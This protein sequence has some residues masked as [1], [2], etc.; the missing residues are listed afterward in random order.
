MVP[1]QKGR[2]TEISLHPGA[3]AVSLLDLLDAQG[4]AIG[5]DTRAADWRMHVPPPPE[6]PLSTRAEYLWILHTTVGDLRIRLMPQH[7]PH[8]VLNVAWLTRIGFY[9]GL[10]FHRIV[11][12]FV[13]QGGDPSGKGVGGPGYKLHSEIEGDG[14]RFDRRGVVAMANSGPDTEG[15][16]FFV[17]FAPAPHLDGNQTIVGEVV[18]GD[19]V[20]TALEAKGSPGGNPKSTVR[21]LTAELVVR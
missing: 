20:L 5:L 17:T 6:I 10:T 15:S 21:I 12:G 8:N 1:P 19:E 9:D 3:R 16:Q 2:P 11:A 4:Q 14:P 13:A 18:E 7:A